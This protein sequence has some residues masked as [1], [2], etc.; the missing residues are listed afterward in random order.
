MNDIPKMHAVP[1]TTIGVGGPATNSRPIL[2]GCVR[3]EHHGERHCEKGLLSTYSVLYADGLFLT[4]P[5]LTAGWKT[6]HEAARGQTNDIGRGA[7]E[8]DDESVLLALAKIY[9]STLKRVEDGC[10]EGAVH[11]HLDLHSHETLNKE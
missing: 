4:H 3:Q 10:F 9:Q 1:N 7:V 2:V 11:G 6:K 5:M 8:V